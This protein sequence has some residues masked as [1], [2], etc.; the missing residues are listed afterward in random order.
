[1]SQEKIDLNISLREIDS[2]LCEECKR[3]LRK[4][5]REKLPDQLI[6]KAI[7]GQK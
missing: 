7:S 3:K 2:I 1:M 6:E 5:I 4:L